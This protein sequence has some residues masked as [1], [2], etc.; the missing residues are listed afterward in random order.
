MFV[1]T[2]LHNHDPVS[3]LPGFKDAFLAGERGTTLVYP[4]CS[5]L[6][7]ELFLHVCFLC[8]RRRSLK[9]TSNLMLACKLLLKMLA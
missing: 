5:T 6:L 2:L 4:L 9:K 1:Q 8:S 3:P 7:Q